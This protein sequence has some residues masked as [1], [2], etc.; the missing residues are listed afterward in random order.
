M[1]VSG[2][3]VHLG[4]VVLTGFV[5]MGRLVMM[6][7]RSIVVRGGIM[8]MLASG[9]LGLFGHNHSPG[10][11]L[12]GASVPC[13]KAAWSTPP[14][15]TFPQHWCH[16]LGF[17]T[18]RT[19]KAIEEMPDVTPIVIRMR[20]DGRTLQDIADHLNEEEYATRKGS[21]WSATQ[22]ARL[23]DRACIHRVDR[24]RRA[25]PRDAV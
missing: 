18:K 13:W 19:A 21:C 5:V 15:F 3:G 7:S 9:V 2:S 14:V 17:A 4:L 1:F 24:R 6:M 8:V 23:L 16:H 25:T 11:H 20:S 22:V 12:G 10:W